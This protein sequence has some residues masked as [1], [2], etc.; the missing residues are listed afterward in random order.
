MSAHIRPGTLPDCR[1]WAN[2]APHFRRP[3][4]PAIGLARNSYHRCPQASQLVAYQQKDINRNAGGSVKSW[5]M[6]PEI[7]QKSNVNFLL[8]LKKWKNKRP[9]GAV[10][11]AKRVPSCVCSSRRVA[12]M[13]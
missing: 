3:A 12:G 4:Q 11:Q 1:W 6:G 10:F 5:S 2:C 9:G 13:A 7:F 8:N